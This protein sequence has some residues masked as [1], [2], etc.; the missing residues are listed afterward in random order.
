MSA[1]SMFI[2][3]AGLPEPQVASFE[4]LVASL[5]RPRI[6]FP[7]ACESHA[8]LEIASLGPRSLSDVG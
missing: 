8:S 5:A 4:F 6:D 2:A 7:P 1:P 3:K